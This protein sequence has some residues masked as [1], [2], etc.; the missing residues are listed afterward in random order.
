[1]LGPGDS[2][3]VEFR[4]LVAEQLAVPVLHHPH[5]VLVAAVDL[6]AAH[7]WV[8]AVNYFNAHGVS[9]NIIL[10]ERAGAAVGWTYHTAPGFDPTPGRGARSTEQEPA[11]CVIAQRP[12][13]A[14]KIQGAHQRPTLRSFLK[15]HQVT[16]TVASAI[17]T[18]IA[19][20]VSV[21]LSL[22]LPIRHRMGIDFQVCFEHA[23]HK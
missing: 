7:G 1:M 15:D 16:F 9:M 17:A 14:K 4:L 21:F 11:A 23:V 3:T 19:I 12:R 10:E 18:A 13:S 8:G 22:V 2:T 20:C 6:V 5:A